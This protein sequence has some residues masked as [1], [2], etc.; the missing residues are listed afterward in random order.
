MQGETYQERRGEIEAYFDRTAADAWARLTSDAPV[1]GIRATVRKG[2]DDMRATLL[3]WLPDDLSGRRIL[4]AGCGPGMLSIEAARRGAEVVAVDLSPTLLDL[5]RERIPAD[6]AGRVT[7]VAGDMLSPEFGHFDHVVAMDSII[8]YRAED[9]VRV[10]AGL[11]ART[12]RSLVFTFAPRTKALA[13]MHFVGG[14][15]PRSDRAPS[16]EPVRE[17]RL[18]ELIA[19]DPD[20]ARWRPGRTRRIAV[21][22]YTSQAL[23]LVPS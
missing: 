23:E 21:G 12:S 6:L 3:S 22:F 8:H 13:L 2:R 19:A 10:I 20:L 7:F 15:F 18:Y 17:E 4:D 1:S 11:A 9:A 5:A 16:I 14:F